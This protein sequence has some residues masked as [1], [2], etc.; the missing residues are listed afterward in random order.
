MGVRHRKQLHSN[1]WCNPPDLEVLNVEEVVNP[2]L[3]RA[4]ATKLEDIEGL[5]RGA[6]CPA[7][8]P[9]AHLQLKKWLLTVDHA[10]EDALE[11]FVLLVNVPD[12]QMIKNNCQEMK[13]SGS[14]TRSF[15]PVHLVVALNPAHKRR[16]GYDRYKE[17]T[18]RGDT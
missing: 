18:T 13:V 1:E 6:G 15:D 11:G 4:Y 9:I 14:P 2:Q 10:E 12:L 3:F 17:R 8:G 16:C 5:R 7:I